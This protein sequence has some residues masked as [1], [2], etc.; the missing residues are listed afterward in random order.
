[1]ALALLTLDAGQCD[2]SLQQ[3][4]G[5]KVHILEQVPGADVEFGHHAEFVVPAVHA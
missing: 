2:L 3:G 1:M 5:G 4:F